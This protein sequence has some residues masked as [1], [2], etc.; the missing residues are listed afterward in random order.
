MYS[1]L[2]ELLADRNLI[3]LGAPPVF[4]ALL[5]LL[6]IKRQ[7]RLKAPEINQ[8]TDVASTPET[9]SDPSAVVH[10]GLTKSRTNFLSRIRGV[11][12]GVS[13]ESRAVFEALEE[14]LIAADLGVKTTQRLLHNV[15][16]RTDKTGKAELSED[17][18][19]SLLK[20]DMLA[21][22]S[23]VERSA[24]IVPDVRRPFVVLVVGVNGVGK[25]TTVGKLAARLGQQ[26]YRVLLGACDTFRAAA[27]Q[28][29]DVWATRAN[30]EIVSGADGEK[31]S[32][33]AYR[34]I[35]RAKSG[36]FDVVLI[37]TAGRLHTRVPLM[38]ELKAVHALIARELPG[39]PHETILVLD[40]TTGQ[41]ALQQAR[42]FNAAVPL[43]GIV[44]TKLDGT[45][46]GGIVVAIKD[47]LGV[48]IRYIG[49]GERLEDLV[50]F[51]PSEFIDGLFAEDAPDTAAFARVSRKRR[52]NED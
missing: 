46:K 27:H 8:A 36:N 22:M 6:L 11:F 29:L 52:L 10:A 42:D 43:S 18:F 3:F 44:V 49:V 31:P 50:P 40:A 5:L 19:K 45:P 38:N 7:R 1:F 9:I 25:T 32:T 48:P 51:A 24:E 23:G 21:I 16:E 2:I 39:S 33:V 12:G 34:T 28:Q 26:G 30:A 17:A 47:E 14:A 41:N 37:D 4:G 20:Q 35:E 13:V 15:R